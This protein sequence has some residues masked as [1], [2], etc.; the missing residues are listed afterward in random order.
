MAICI[1][2]NSFPD[3][4]LEYS[5]YCTTCVGNDWRLI[6]KTPVIVSGQHKGQNLVSK[7]DS[8]THN[9]S[10]GE[11]SQPVGTYSLPNTKIAVRD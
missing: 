10:G 8:T 9:Y 7:A 5:D 11:C 3:E 6:R 4:R 2:G 1:C